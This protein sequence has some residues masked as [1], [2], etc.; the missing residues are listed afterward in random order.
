[1]GRGGLA[2]GFL[3]GRGFVFLE[4]AGGFRGGACWGFG[5]GWFWFRVG[6]W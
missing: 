2:G 3:A 4:W 1:L 5:F 6:F